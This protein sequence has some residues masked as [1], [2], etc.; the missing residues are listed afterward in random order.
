[1]TLGDIRMSQ[2]RLE[3]A[4]PLYQR[5]LAI[6]RATIGDNHYVT[7]DCCY[8]LAKHMNRDKRYDEAR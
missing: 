1:M 5:A 4:G 7:A 6:F 8:S 3:E 2:N